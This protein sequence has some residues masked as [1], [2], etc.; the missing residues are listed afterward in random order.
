MRS[1]AVRCG[2][3]GSARTIRKLTRLVGPTITR[4]GGVVCY[5]P[6]ALQP[7]SRSGITSTRS[8][9]GRDVDGAVLVAV[10]DA[11]RS[12]RRRKLRTFANE[13]PSRRQPAGS[14]SG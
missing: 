13:V 4:H 6:G 2:L 10:D 14:L 8:A 12:P 7:G 1:R 5:E 11:L 9:V 3:N